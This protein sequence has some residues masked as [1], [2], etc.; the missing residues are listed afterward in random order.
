MIIYMIKLSCLYIE[1]RNDLSGLLV[2]DHSEVIKLRM[3]TIID[4]NSISRI[5]TVSEIYKA[6]KAYI[7]SILVFMSS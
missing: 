2:K 4:T 3:S 5:N 6:K 1:Q 7:F